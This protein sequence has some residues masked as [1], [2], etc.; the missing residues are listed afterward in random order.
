MLAGLRPIKE[1]MGRIGL[2]GGEAPSS[3]I[4]VLHQA[5]RRISRINWEL[6]SR[7]FRNLPFFSI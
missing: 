7:D 4:H 3:V 2:L 1:I 5:G 6:G